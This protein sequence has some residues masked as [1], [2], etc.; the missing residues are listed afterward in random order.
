LKSEILELESTQSSFNINSFGDELEEEIDATKFR[1]VLESYFKVNIIVLEIN[2]E[3]EHG[4]FAI[5]NDNTFITPTRFQFEEVVV[6]TKIT[7]LKRG[8]G[9]T[10]YNLVIK[11]LPKGLEQYKFKKDD[12]F[13]RELMKA[14]EL[15]TKATLVGV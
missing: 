14:Y 10:Q 2:L 4:V 1:R 15:T 7:K 11:V 12:P 13:V 6:L 9:K 5:E 8:D 3:N